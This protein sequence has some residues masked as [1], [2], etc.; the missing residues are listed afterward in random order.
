MN[1][2]L[3]KYH[4][5]VWKRRLVDGLLLRGWRFRMPDTL[6]I[7]TTNRCTL[8]CS[9][10]PNGI[11][12]VKLR[13][14]GVM[15]R[16]TFD[17]VLQN[18]DF[19]AR[20]CFLHLC[21]EPFLNKDLVYFARQLM[22]RKILPVVFSNGYRIDEGLLRELL[23][24]RGVKIAFS[25]DL[26]S[27]AH[28]EQI[29]TPA[30]Y[31]EAE[32]ALLR[33]DRIFAEAKRH[34]GLNMIVDGS[35][36]EDL[37]AVCQSLFDRFGQLNT[38][39][40]SVAWPWPALPHTGDLSGHLASHS[41][42]CNQASGMLSVLWNGDVAFCSFDYSGDTVVGSMLK[43]S[44]RHLYNAPATR[45]LRRQLLMTHRADNPLC[46]NCLLGRFESQSKLFTRASFE[47]ATPEE[48]A[49]MFLKFQ[50][51]DPSNT[52]NL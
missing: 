19:P 39:S 36:A 14:R 10:C 2:A 31:E 47:R 32:A 11:P 1:K 5:R 30:R 40:L 34:Y 33:I 51:K 43:D 48:R 28:Y 35:H 52:V 7:E 50:K 22:A 4:F 26:L 9:C 45:R 16:E 44:Y 13:E 42:L 20:Q 46:A 23:S 49:R 17:R 25:M 3:L 29:R 27:K 12:G 15:T 37:E 8:A 24:V 18:L 38:I 21:G 41:D 6:V